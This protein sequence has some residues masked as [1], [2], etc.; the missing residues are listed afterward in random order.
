MQTALHIYSLAGE[1]KDKIAGAKFIGTEFYK[2]EREAYI[3]FKSDSGVLALG[4]IYHPVSHGSFVIPRGKVNVET[5]EKPWPFFQDA[6]GAEVTSVNQLGFDRIIKIELNKN[7]EKYG[8]I[9]EAIGPNGNFWLTDGGGYILA[10]LRNRDFDKSKPYGPPVP[11]TRLNPF[12]VE[13]RHL[14][15]LFRKSDQFAE[16]VLKKSVS[17]LDKFLIEEILVRSGIELHCPADEIDDDSLKMIEVQ[18]KNV[19]NQFKDYSRG[20]FYNIEDG[21]LAYPFKLHSL[22]EAHSKC[23]SLSFAVYEAIRTKKIARSEIDEKQ[24]TLEAISRYVKRLKRKI[25]KIESDITSAANFEQYKKY[26]ELLKINIKNIRKGQDEVELE[27]V[28]SVSGEKVTVKLDPALAPAQN[29]DAYFK[30]YRKGREGLQ[31]LERRLEIAIGEYETAMGIQ[32]DFENDYEQAR[33]K[34]DAEITSILPKTADKKM[35]RVRLPYKEAV[36]SSGVTVFIGRE[37]PDNDTTTFQYAKPYELW[38]HASQCPG[39]HVVM[40]FPSKSFVPS[41]FEIEETAAIAAYHSKARNSSRVPVIYTQRRYV[42]KPRGA[43]AGL[44]TVQRE[45]MVMVEPTKPE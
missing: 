10:T 15:E 17:G 32:V 24:A 12:D 14:I 2:K 1:L 43:K 20:Y 7:G 42:R 31:L 40:K 41:R 19:Y 44:V 38:F 45:K 9:V 21:N 26:A 35:A 18:I 36:L 3:H 25:T 8:I 28:Y 34:Y 16:N 5:R 30:K 33:Q 37:G 11:P 29:A 13:L 27:D 39:S 4:L 23:K 22:G 6:W